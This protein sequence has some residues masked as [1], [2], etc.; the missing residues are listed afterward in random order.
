MFSLLVTA[1]G[2][3]QYVGTIM[4]DLLH[5]IEDFRICL[6]EGRTEEL[7]A[8]SDSPYVNVWKT[9][10]TFCW[11]SG[12]LTLAMPRLM[13]GCH[14]GDNGGV[15][16]LR[17]HVQQTE[18]GRNAALMAMLDFDTLPGLLIVKAKG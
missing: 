10:L 5:N 11:L 13:I 7:F 16:R 9:C 18:E 2:R 1:W 14:G 8:I 12:V 15:L 17:R 4:A 3:L 6:F